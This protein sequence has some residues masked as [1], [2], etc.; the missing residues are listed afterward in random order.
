M[1]GDL[2]DHGPYGGPLASDRQAST[3]RRRWKPGL[4]LAAY[5]LTLFVLVTAN[6]VLPRALPGDPIDALLDT[7]APGHVQ[8]E[9]LRS[10]LA[11]YYELDRPLTEQYGRYLAGLARGDLGVSIRYHVPVGQ[12]LR[13]RLPWTLVLVSA[14][15]A[16]AVGVGWLAGIHSGW[17][18]ERRADRSLLTLFLGLHSFPVFFVGSVALFLFSVRLGWFPLA[19]ARTPFLDDAGLLRRIADA[20]HHLVLPALVLAA[21]FVTS[22]YLTMR[23]AMVGELGSDHLLL[24]RAKGLTERRIKY[25]YAARSALLPGITLAAIHVSFAITEAIVIETVFSYQ[26]AGRLIFEGVAYRDYPALQGCFLVLS[27]VVVTANLLA[28]L[29]YARLDPR[30][31]PR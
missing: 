22:Q 14:A 30:T 9:Q 18:R 7:G 28:D 3:R 26:G 4:R 10:Q 1:A 11:A 12:L 25:R 17:R 29:L 5:G 20:A 13:E 24:G 31:T 23:A 27:V 19:G 15:L 16:V 2:E 8:D 21:A 6:F